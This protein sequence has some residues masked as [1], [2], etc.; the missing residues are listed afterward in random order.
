VI[1]AVLVALAAAAVWFERRRRRRARWRRVLDTPSRVPAAA[2]DW[3]RSVAR[4]R[5]PLRV[6]LPLAA[7][8]GACLGTGLGGPVAGAVLGTY[9][10]VAAWALVRVRARRDESAS[11]RQAM[12]AVSGL[13]AELRAGLPLEA[14]TATTAL[15]SPALVGRPAHAVVGRVEAAIQLAE[16]S[17]APLADVLERLEVHLRALDRA[18]VT[19]AA[20]AAGARVSALLLAAMPVAG[21]GLGGL[22]AVDPAPVLLRTRL[23][24]AC[25][26]AAVALQLGGLAWVSR[27]SRT[28]VPT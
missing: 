12:D 26:L 9:C 27:L 10:G 17:G 3:I 24:A 8:A 7:I 21:T 23:G 4:I 25:L 15:R 22:L 11:W 1:A 14:A 16:S 28:E 6:A 5:P 13:A 19:A 18:R 2:R 20:Q